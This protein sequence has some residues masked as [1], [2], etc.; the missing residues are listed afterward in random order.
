MAAIFLNFFQCVIIQ[1]CFRIDRLLKQSNLCSQNIIKDFDGEVSA[2]PEGINR[3]F[4]G[5]G[6]DALLYR[7]ILGIVN[8][9]ES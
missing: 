6:D 4:H 9:D 3:K 1:N 8:I 7:R 5:K 2:P